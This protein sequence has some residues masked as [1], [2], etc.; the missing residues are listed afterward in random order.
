MGMMGDPNPAFLFTEA[1][2]EQMIRTGLGT[3]ICS[4]SGLFCTTLCLALSFRPHWLFSRIVSSSPSPVVCPHRLSLSCPLFWS[5]HPFG[6]YSITTCISRLQEP[7]MG[8]NP[9]PSPPPQGHT[10]MLLKATPMEVPPRSPAEVLTGSSP[11]FPSPGPQKPFPSQLLSETG[12]SHFQRPALDSRPI[13]QAQPRSLRLGVIWTKKWCETVTP[14]LNELE[15]KNTIHH[16]II[17]PHF[18]G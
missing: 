1:C 9:T 13:L 6:C 15:R 5:P 10:V 16:F 17:L 12:L 14:F 11:P 7:L 8:L 18:T 3:K 4:L 2:A